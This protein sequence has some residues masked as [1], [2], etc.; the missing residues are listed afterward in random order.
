MSHIAS[1]KI[2][3]YLPSD[4]KVTGTFVA[5]Y[6]GNDRVSIATDGAH[7]N[8]DNLAA[9]LFALSTQLMYVN[10]TGLFQEYQVLVDFNRLSLHRALRDMQQAITERD[11]AMK[12]GDWAAYGDADE[13][14]R[15][16]LQ[17]AIELQ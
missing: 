1:P 11:E 10:M 5:V 12:A 3:H 14:L 4:G 8:D 16:A 15:D 7:I 13:R 9:E 6:I 17:R 2:R